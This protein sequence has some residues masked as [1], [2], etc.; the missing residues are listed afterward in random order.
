ME[1]SKRD[2]I[3]TVMRD[4]LKTITKKDNKRRVRIENY[5]EG[6]AVDNNEEEL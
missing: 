5:D 6:G 4:I 1:T 3:H 2:E